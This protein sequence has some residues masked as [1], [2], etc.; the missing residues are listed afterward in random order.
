MV[1]R[2]AWSKPAGAVAHWLARRAGV[3]DPEIGWRCLEGPLFDNQ[4]A[5]LEFDGRRASLRLDKAASEDQ[6]SDRRL[7][8]SFERRLS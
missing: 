3:P 7:E 4:V 1:I 2:A 5:T 8:E 6:G